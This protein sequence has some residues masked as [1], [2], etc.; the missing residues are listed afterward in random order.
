MDNNVDTLKIEVESTT[1]DAQRGLTKL[2]NSLEK[3]T[4]LSE[5]V[6][7]INGEGISKLKA[8]GEAIDRIGNAGT[9]P[10]LSKAI[11]ELSKLTN[12]DF[13]N[14][15]VGSAKLSEI[16]SKV[17]TISSNTP[18]K[19][20][21][22]NAKVATTQTYDV[23]TV[24]V[25]KATSNFE[26]VKSVATNVFTTIRNGAKWSFS[27]IGKLVKAG[28]SGGV[29]A[30]KLLAK[31]ANIALGSVKSFGSYMK[32]KLANA[33]GRVAKK[34]LELVRA[35]GRI[36]VYRTIRF[37]LSQITQAFKDGTNNLYQ[38]SKAIN[39]T[40]AQSMD[41][42]A[43]SFLY[44]KNS[45]GAM[46]S[47]L[48]NALAPA[49][50]YVVNKIVSLIEVMGQLFAKLTGAKTW[51]RAVRTQTQYAEA[52]GEAAEAT[53]EAAQTMSAGFDEL[54]VI[55]Q[56]QDKGNDMDKAGGIDYGSMFEEVP[57]DSDF[58]SWIDQIKE[59]ISRGDWY[60]VG[61]ILA[62]KVNEVVD[63]INYAGIGEKLGTGIT[64]AFQVLYGF[65][66]NLDGKR[67][68]EGVSTFLNSTMNTV[69]STLIGLTLGAAL[70]RVFDVAYGMVVTFDWS[71]FGQSVADGI[72][73]L[74]IEFDLT[75]AIKTIETSVLG[76]LESISTLFTGYNWR[77]LG[78]KVATAINS[79]NWVELFG[80]LSTTLSDILVGVFDLV[81]GVV[82]TLDFSKIGTDI[83]E[84]VVA[85]IE[86]IDWTA[87]TVAL[88]KLLGAAIAGLGSYIVTGWMTVFDMFEQGWE[89]IQSYFLTHIE[90]AGGDVG[91]GFLN[92][93]GAWFTDIGEWITTNITDPFV[94]A[95]KE[96]FEINSGSSKLMEE[97]GVAIAVGAVLGITSPI[98]WAPALIF[99]ATQ[100]DEFEKLFDDGFEGITERVK[101]GLKV[102]WS[103]FDT[104]LKET[105]GKFDTWLS[106]QKQSISTWFTERKNDATEALSILGKVLLF[107]L[108]ELGR[109]VVEAFSPITEGVT[110]AI[111]WVL[112]KVDTLK[113]KLGEAAASISNF[114][115]NID[116]GSIGSTIAGFAGN[117]L[118]GVFG[119]ADGGFP[120]VGELFIARESGAEMVGSIGGRTAVANNDQI[121]QGIYEGVLA[122]MQ[123]SNN[124]GGNFDVK[125]Y[126]DG[127]QVTAAVERRQRER[128][129]TI[130]PGG[131][132][133]GI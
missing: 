128:G 28:L 68:G 131:V 121:V 16:A 50:E 22:T 21:T 89:D 57:L 31:G 4:Q 1:T 96:T 88:A 34:A 30:L 8:M 109:S 73:G 84:S 62:E 71:K 119:Y 7:K 42:L 110:N 48:I 67:I 65:T 86:G 72:S 114:F 64:N 26:R 80:S 78:E 123:S 55:T 120:E 95:F 125:V 53:E 47:P 13:S 54:N 12:M 46:V 27:G 60:G 49:V 14:L 20:V 58:A 94:E 38:F 40:F 116:F 29:N 52:A 2:K 11:K 44:L 101:A 91:Q 5:G 102:I 15:S 124:N 85:I 122:A 129:A 87:I 111:D 61:E 6:A 92:G 9:N 59:A 112:E 106:E 17:A 99:I 81:L 66:K 127:K 82:T 10:G 98:A 83:V 113:E 115:S 79:I 25:N 107:A 93:I 130:Y 24:D 63:R 77:S 97:N 23:P 3:L 108:S 43:S 37:L 75:H 32:G 90:E 133:N 69:D 35:I 41:S 100:F 45:I 105:K 56:E 126:L 51:T 74:F 70:N 132:L 117:L 33:M 18:T 104:W 103:P 39:G 36:A 19:V 118:G 76:L